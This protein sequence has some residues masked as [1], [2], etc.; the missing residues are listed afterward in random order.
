M[1]VLAAVPA[2]AADEW[3]RVTTPHFEVYT[4]AGERRGRDIAREFEK[5]REFFERASPLKTPPDAPVRIILF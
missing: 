4:T 5:V 3:I 2:L 1:L